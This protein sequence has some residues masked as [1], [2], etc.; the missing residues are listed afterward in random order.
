MSMEIADQRSR[1]AG[2]IIEIETHPSKCVGCLLCQLIC[3]FNYEKM[4][5]PSKSR[6]LIERSDNGFKINFAD[7]CT[8]CGLCVQFCVYDALEAKR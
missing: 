2:K 6:I 4:F 5:N 8:L 3:S 1:L 7:E